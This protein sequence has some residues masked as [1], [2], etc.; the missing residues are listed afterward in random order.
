MGNIG[1][2]SIAITFLQL[3][4]FAIDSHLNV[5]FHQVANLVMRMGVDWN[6]N[7]SLKCEL[8]QHQGLA[9]CQRAAGYSRHRL[10][11]FGVLVFK[12]HGY[13]P[14]ETCFILVL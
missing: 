4:L 3:I 9:L 10:H 7:V 2:C 13:P 6:G 1:W 14:L 12:N 11:R 5:S 8:T